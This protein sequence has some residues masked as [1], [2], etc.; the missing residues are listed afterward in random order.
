MVY[1]LLLKQLYN[2]YRR[3]G[4]IA[5]VDY[6]VKSFG[7][8]TVDRYFRGSFSQKAEDIIIDRYFEHKKRGFYIDIGAYHPKINSN[9]KFFYNR[10]WH[11]INIEPNPERIKL[12]KQFRRRDINLN[13]GVGASKKLETFYELEATGLSTFSKRE[14][15]SMLKVGHKLK[16]KMKI[17]MYRLQDIMKKY[18]KNEVDFITIDTEAL[19]LEVLEGNNW[20]KYR[21]KLI[22]IETIDFADLLTSTKDD[23]SRKEEISKY[24][25]RKGYEEYFSNGLNTLYIDLNQKQTL[26]Y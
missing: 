4:A 8:L 21:P 24:L 5:L 7:Y 1:R 14:A 12:F 16:S 2:M 25:L 11:G 3:Q 13:A 26:K 15:D 20:D 23:S 17:Q 22:C 6:L 10:G 18:V 9:T 19:D